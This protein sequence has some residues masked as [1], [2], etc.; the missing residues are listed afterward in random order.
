MMS[1]GENEMK[2]ETAV[3]I[4]DIEM[5][6]TYWV[7][8]G[9]NRRCVMHPESPMF[10]AAWKSPKEAKD[11]AKSMGVGYSTARQVKD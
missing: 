4:R 2:T 7:V 9:P 6:A 11:A 10:K 5:G 3:D 8:V 1:K